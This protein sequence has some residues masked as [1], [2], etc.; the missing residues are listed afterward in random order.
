MI[1]NTDPEQPIVNEVEVVEEEPTEEV[2]PVTET[3]LV[4]TDEPVPEEE[5]I[6]EEWYPIFDDEG[7]V[8]GTSD[9]E[10]IEVL[11]PATNVIVI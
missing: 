9:G 6:I 8:V 5:D 11:S 3:E 4:P 1:D 10:Y 2:E 7:D